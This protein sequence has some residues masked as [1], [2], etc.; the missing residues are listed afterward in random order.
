MLCEKHSGDK[1]FENVKQE[2]INFGGG[3]LLGNAGPL[4]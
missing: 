3:G 4:A 2:A 1:L